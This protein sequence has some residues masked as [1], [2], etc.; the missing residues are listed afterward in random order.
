MAMVVVLNTTPERAFRV[1][2]H[3]TALGKINS[4]VQQSQLLKTFSPLKHRVK[5]VTS[6]CVLW[7]CQ[8]I[9]QIQDMLKNPRTLHLQAT[10]TENNPDFISGYASWHFSAHPKGT[11]MTFDSMIEPAFW[12]P[13]LIGPWAVSNMLTSQADITSVGLE[14]EASKLP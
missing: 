3:Y 5:T 12:I 13:P 9:T 8:T 14:R 1:M 10:L 2:T 6:V 7:V 4:A 11:K